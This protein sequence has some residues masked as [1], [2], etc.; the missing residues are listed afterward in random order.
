MPNRLK[1]IHDDQLKQLLES[2]GLTARFN[3]GKLTCS[4]CRDPISWDNL[5][6]IFP[7]SGAIKVVCQRMECLEALAAKIEDAKSGVHL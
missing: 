5:V 6:A 2:L 3:E 1:T 4:F 7:D